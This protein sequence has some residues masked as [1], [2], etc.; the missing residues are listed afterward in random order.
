MNAIHEENS[1]SRM[2]RS[3]MPA[4]CLPC[5][6]AGLVAIGVL[7]GW[8]IDSRLLISIVP[9]LTAMNPL[10]AV[11]FL[12]CA[13]GI[14]VAARSNGIGSKITTWLGGTVVFLASGRLFSYVAG[15][16]NVPDSWLFAEKL[17]LEPIP[18]RMAPNTALAFVVVGV[19]LVLFNRPSRHAIHPSEWLLV[20]AISI[21]LLTVVGYAYSASVIA[22]VAN[23]I[24]MALHTGILFAAIG[25]GALMARPN[26][27]L[28]AEISGH[29]LGSLVARR[30]LWALTGVPLFA[31]LLLVEGSEADLFSPQVGAAAMATVSVAALSVV[32][33]SCARMLNQIESQRQAVLDALE[34]AE[35]DAVRANRAKSEFLSRMS[36]E[37]RTPLN[38][39]LGFAQL[40]E[41]TELSDRQKSFVQHIERGGRH[42]LDLINEVLDISRIETGRLSMSIEPV[43]LRAIVQQAVSLSTPHA[44]A[45]GVNLT[46]EAG[47]EHQFVK[48]DRQRLTQI[49]LNLISNAIKY[50]HEGGHVGL[51]VD[52][53]ADSAVVLRCADTGVGIPKDHLGKL[54]APFERLGADAQGF[55]GTGLGLAVSR[56]LAEAMGGKLDLESTG[57]Q[58]SSFVLKLE[59]SA[60]PQLSGQRPE[61]FPHDAATF[62]RLAG[63]RILQIEDNP[64][65]VGLME[66]AIS[67]WTAAEL[68]VAMQGSIGLDLARQNAPDVILLDLNLPDMHG[69][70]VLKRLQRDTATNGIPVIIVSADGTQVQIDRMLSAGASDYLT[71]PLNL[72]QLFDRIESLLEGRKKAA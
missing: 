66:N 16:Q 46:F 10:T 25:A 30:L 63:V 4:A 7:L 24:P 1:G 12:L 69:A 51:R 34:S 36:H 6:F 58:G 19:A 50:N 53:D 56:R 26:R 33:W 43:D 32:A 65:N 45:K 14:F 55:E 21:G 35:L 23:Q 11:C 28:M 5:V 60:E 9:G 3:A 15:I 70:E 62:R 37:L 68:I 67:Q 38:S 2:L 44:Q 59:A 13:A 49:A 20:S 41:A 40:L 39:V 29:R 57:D 18:N 42:L 22:S 54:F 64:A 71:K 17:A 72:S 27:G 61:G 48:G 31:G 52:E 8:A 47:A